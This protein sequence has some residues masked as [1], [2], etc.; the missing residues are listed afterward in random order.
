MSSNF[1]VN[2]VSKNRLGSYTSDCAVYKRVFK[3]LEIDRLCSFNKT[4]VIQMI[5]FQISLKKPELFANSLHLIINK[6]PIEYEIILIK[7][8]FFCNILSKNFF[9]KANISSC[10]KK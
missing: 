10:F 6:F 3:N 2:L 1:D 9:L 7:K 8:V 5:G 4:L